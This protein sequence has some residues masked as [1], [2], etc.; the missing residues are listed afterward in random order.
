MA[1]IGR[2]I[3]ALILEGEMQPILSMAKLV[4]DFNYSVAWDYQNCILNSPEGIRI[5]CDRISSCPNITP[6]TRVLYPKKYKAM[7]AKAFPST[8]LD[9]PPTPAVEEPL[10]N[11]SSQLDAEAEDTGIFGND[12]PL[13]PLPSIEPDSFVDSPYGHEVPSTPPNPLV[14][15]DEDVPHPPEQPELE[16]GSGPAFRKRIRKRIRHGTGRSIPNSTA[17]TNGFRRSASY[18]EGIPPNSHLHVE[19]Q[20]D[21]GD[22]LVR[23]RPQWYRG[24]MPLPGHYLTHFPKHPGCDICNRCRVIRKQRRRSKPKEI[25]ADFSDEPAKIFADQVTLDHMIIGDSD[26]NS[27]QGDTVS[28]II[29]DRATN[30]LQ[31]YPAKNK[32]GRSVVVAFQS[33]FGINCRPKLIFS[34]NSK[35]IQMACEHLLYSHDTSTPHIPPI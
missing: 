4:D 28:L 2:T 3:R 11:I 5:Y 35:E 32:S 34:D 21:S 26:D 13:T 12:I 20:L 31:A 30:W 27:F 8:Q 25:V 29:K 7:L 15:D 10:P 19:F 16:L 14:E 6:T 18:E 24:S 17:S 23:K 22:P 33:Y 9:T 1:I